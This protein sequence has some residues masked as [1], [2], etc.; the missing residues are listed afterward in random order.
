MKLI[1]MMGL[2]LVAAIAAM[3]LLGPGSASATEICSENK[4]PCPEAKLIKGEITAQLQP[5]TQAL[6]KGALGAEVHCQK[7]EAGGE[8]TENP[9]KNQVLGKIT[10]LTFEECAVGEGPK[11]CKIES[12]QK[13]YTAHVSQGE[14]AGE[15]TL[16]VGPQPGGETPGAKFVENCGVFTGCNYKVNESQPGYEGQWAKLS[17]QNEGGATHA[18]AEQVALKSSFFCGGNSGRWVAAYTMHP[19]PMWVI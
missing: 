10:K 16:Y 12:L 6:L 17:L 14:K 18:H 8:I 9:S 1:K 2:A 13:P 7:S 19:I 5:E 3:A 15:G 4:S 11:T